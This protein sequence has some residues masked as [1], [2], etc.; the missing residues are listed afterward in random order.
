MKSAN[1]RVRLFTY[2]CVCLTSLVVVNGQLSPALNTLESLSTWISEEHGMN[3][4]RRDRGI[5]GVECRGDYCDDKRLLTRETPCKLKW[6][7]KTGYISEEVGIERGVRRRNIAY[8]G[9]NALAVGIA[10]KGDYCDEMAVHCA[11]YYDCDI[12][13]PI[14]STSYFSE[15][16]HYRKCPAGTVVVGFKCRGDYCD[17]LRLYCRKL[18]INN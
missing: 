8:C 3:D 11:N 9:D 1:V 18:T 7:W 2:V 4:Y 6:R 14:Y 13:G 17:D 5:I 12:G 10:C 16:Q 15:E